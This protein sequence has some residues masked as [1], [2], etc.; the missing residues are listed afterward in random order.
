MALAY[1][2]NSSGYNG[3][4]A[5]STS[6]SVTVTTAP[7]AGR[8]VVACINRNTNDAIVNDAGGAPWTQAINEGVTSETAR[9]AVFWKIAGASEPST[10]TFSFNSGDDYYQMC[11][12]TFSSS[13]DAEIVESPSIVRDTSTSGDIVCEASDGITVSSGEVGIVFGGKD[14]RF[15]SGGTYTTATGG[16]VNVL[17]EADNQESAMAHKIFSSG[18]TLGVITLSSAG[19]TAT[20]HTYSVYLSFRESSGA[21]LSIPIAMY[22]RR[23]FNRG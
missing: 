21:G 17:G 23:Q 16:F 19:S 7:P 6:A 14:N 3:G 9:L 12:Q 1:E 8:L 4:D 22:H 15:G 5:S 11:V 10:Y 18:E 20:D 2:A 13:T